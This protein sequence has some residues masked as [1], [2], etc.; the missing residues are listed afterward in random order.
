MEVALQLVFDHVLIRVADCAASGAFY[1]TVLAPLGVESFEPLAGITRWENFGITE[2]DAEHPVTR[3]LH[4]G[5]VAASREHVDAFW[6][7]GTGAGYRDAGVPGPRPQYSEHYY[8]AFLLD[9]DGNSVEA[10]HRSGLAAAGLIDHLWIRVAD[11]AAAR[12]FYTT[13]AP[14]TG[15][16]LTAD[17]PQRAGF[18]GDAGEFSLLADE[19]TRTANLHIAFSARDD[20]TVRAFH[21]AATGAGFTDNG[22]P[23]PRPLYGPGYHGAFVL[24]PDAN[25]VEVVH[26]SD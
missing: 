18:E 7:A 14:H 2:T 1:A 23:G 19:R 26:M 17:T 5:F 3:G 25:N 11:L 10:V 12:R 15:F 13:I 24:D 20:A 22:A 21:E 6:R 9:P 4:V 16:A 8:G